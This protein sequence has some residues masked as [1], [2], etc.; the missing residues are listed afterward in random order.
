MNY[1]LDA[2]GVFTAMLVVGVLGL[3]IAIAGQVLL[4]GGW[5]SLAVISAGLIAAAYGFLMS[6][7][8]LWSSRIGKLRTRER[9]LDTPATPLPHRPGSSNL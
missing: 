1:G 5:G 7:H 8:M 4:Q 2:P 9:L 6:G 3:A